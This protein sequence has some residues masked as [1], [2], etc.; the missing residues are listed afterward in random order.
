VDAYKR[1]RRLVLVTCTNCLG[2]GV[3]AT[4]NE[5]KLCPECK[6]K[7]EVEKW[8]VEIVNDDE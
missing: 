3:V 6:G 1:I 2:S 8:V 4:K 7:G 5:Q